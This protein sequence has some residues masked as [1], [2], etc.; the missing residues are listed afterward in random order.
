M[1]VVSALSP[2]SPAAP[3]APIPVIICDT[4][5]ELPFPVIAPVVF[6]SLKICNSSSALNSILPSAWISRFSGYGRVCRYF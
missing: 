2:F 4:D 6:M 3:A 5:K 1:V